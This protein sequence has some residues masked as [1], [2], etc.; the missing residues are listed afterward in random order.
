MSE[1]DEHK[2]T[3]TDRE[4]DGKSENIAVTQN[5]GLHRQKT[6]FSADRTDSDSLMTI[7]ANAGTALHS[8]NNAAIY[9][10]GTLCQ[11][12]IEL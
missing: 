11:K 6:Q 10:P 5:N 4:N 12:D 9:W 3:P 2:I 8:N 1:R 7:A